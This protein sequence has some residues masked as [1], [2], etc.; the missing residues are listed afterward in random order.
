MKCGKCEYTTGT[1]IPDTSSV[2]E[3]QQL[4]LFHLEDIHP[5]VYG[6]EKE[7]QAGQLNCPGQEPDRSCGFCYNHS[8]LGQKPDSRCDL[9]YNHLRSCPWNRK[10]IS[11]CQGEVCK[12]D[13]KK[14][15]NTRVAR[16]ETTDEATD[17]SLEH[18]GRGA[19]LVG[20]QVAGLEEHVEATDVVEVTAEKP[21]KDLEGKCQPGQFLCLGQ[22]PGQ[23]RRWCQVCDDHY[24]GTDGHDFDT[25][26]HYSS[27]DDHYFGTECRGETCQYDMEKS[28]KERVARKETTAE[29]PNYLNWGR[30]AELSGDKVTGLERHVEA[31]DVVEESSSAEVAAEKPS[32]DAKVA[33]KEITD[34][35]TDVGLEHWG[36]GV[37]HINAARVARFSHKN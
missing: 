36:R 29:V 17:V 30:V 6:Q 13:M 2:A 21:S 28:S 27:T 5:K 32:Q 22:L 24:F 9:C 34:E 25:D 23:C 26:D 19:E 12:Y 20:D 10:P 31:T 14:S 11:W 33:R 8:C 35:A 4:M 18:R 15:S 1:M 37:D 7:C 16:E 3:K